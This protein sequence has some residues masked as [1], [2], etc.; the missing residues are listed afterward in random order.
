VFTE[1]LPGNVTISTYLRLGLRS[2]LF[3]S[4]F[5][6]NI[7]HAFLFFHSRATYPAHLTL[8]DLT[9]LIILGEEYDQDTSYPN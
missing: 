8:L 3:P 5:P 2:G 4:G 6:K 1:L 7:L 9:V